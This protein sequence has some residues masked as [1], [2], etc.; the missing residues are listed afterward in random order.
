MTDDHDISGLAHAYRR[1]VLWFG[2]Q[3]FWG[4]QQVLLQPIADELG[5]GVPMSLL[6]LVGSL[7]TVLALVYYGYR[8]AAAFGSTVPWLWASAMLVPLAS[9]LTLLALSSQAARTCKAHGVPVGIFGP[10]VPAVE[11]TV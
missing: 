9:L 2:V 6:L 8:T 5:A 4:A 7:A 10:K 3:L 11:S 1:L